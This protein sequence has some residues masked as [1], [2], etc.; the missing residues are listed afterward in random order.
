MTRNAC[1]SPFAATIFCLSAALCSFDVLLL[2]PNAKLTRF[3]ATAAVVSGRGLYGSIASMG[4]KH[5]STAIKLIND[6][7]QE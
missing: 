2:T 7:K 4:K 1:Q 5:N 6:C 3:L